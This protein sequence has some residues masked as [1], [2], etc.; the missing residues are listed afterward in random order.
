MEVWKGSL[1]EVLPLAR[2][3]LG[4]QSPNCAMVCSLWQLQAESPFLGSLYPA[5]FPVLMPGN[6]AGFRHF[7]S[8]CDPG[9]PETTLSDLGFHPT[10][11]AAFRETSKCSN[12]ALCCYI[13]FLYLAY[14]GSLP[15]PE[16][17]L[18]IYCLRFMSLHLLLCK[19]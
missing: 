6:S 15:P 12:F 18:P 3:L 10:S 13:T 4:E 19:K 7:S 16:V 8:H 17:Y 11:R 14:G 5:G 2:S 9:D 1:A